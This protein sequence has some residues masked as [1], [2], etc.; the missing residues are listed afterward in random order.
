M[1]ALAETIAKGKKHARKVFGQKDVT[2]RDVYTLS[3]VMVKVTAAHR[4]MMAYFV[5]LFVVTLGLLLLPKGGLLFTLIDHGFEQVP[6]MRFI[7]T[8]VTNEWQK[9]LDQYNGEVYAIFIGTVLASVFVVGLCFLFFCYKVYKL[10][11]HKKNLKGCSKQID[12]HKYGIFIFAFYTLLLLVISGAICLEV[13]CHDSE[14]MFTPSCRHY[15]RYL[16]G[17]YILVFSVYLCVGSFHVMYSMKNLRP[18]LTSFHKPTDFNQT[19]F[20]TADTD[21]MGLCGTYRDEDMESCVGSYISDATYKRR[22]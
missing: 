18:N 21:R 6:D 7:N 10:L 2:V 20:S 4:I 15:H 1:Q 12:A 3:S 11:K 19:L 5:Y 14:Q 8:S 16:A 22:Y 9:R 17:T 13:F